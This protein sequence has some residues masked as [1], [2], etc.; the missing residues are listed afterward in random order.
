MPRY[1]D[2]DGSPQDMAKN[3]AVESLIRDKRWTR[4]RW[5]TETT[6]AMFL[7]CSDGKVR[8]TD[9]KDGR[10]S[11]STQSISITSMP[12]TAKQLTTER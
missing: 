4:P 8:V 1:P 5:R 11:N 3:T 2:R 12:T 10:L 7:L 9:L 6:P